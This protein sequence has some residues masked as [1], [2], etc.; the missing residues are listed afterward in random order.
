MIEFACKHCQQS[1]SLSNNKAGIS[2]R[3]PHCT[4]PVTVPTT[5]DLPLHDDVFVELE[6]IHP[7]AVRPDEGNE[8]QI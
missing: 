8:S 2:G 1:I 4:K 5:S 6:P 7:I 3:C